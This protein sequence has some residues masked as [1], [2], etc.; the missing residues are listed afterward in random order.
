[1]M[2]SFLSTLLAQRIAF[3]ECKQLV[4]GYWAPMILQ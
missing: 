2:P 4:E 1:L 3:R